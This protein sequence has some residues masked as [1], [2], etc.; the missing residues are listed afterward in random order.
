MKSGSRS[1]GFAR[2]STAAAR[3]IFAARG[4]NGS[5]ARPAIS[6]AMSGKAR[7]NAFMPSL[8]QALG[9]ELADVFHLKSVLDALDL[10]TEV[11]H[12]QA[13][14]AGGAHDGRR[15]FQR[16]FDTDDVDPLLGW[17]LHPHV[18]APSAAAEPTLA[19]AGQLDRPQS[20]NRSDHLARR[21][22]DP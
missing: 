18:A 22:H 1:I 5:T 20:R 2:Y 21:L 17:H 13:E 14:R 16:L 6:R 12:G 4:N 8:L 9:D 3:A 19:V 7:S 11:D 15:G 10:A